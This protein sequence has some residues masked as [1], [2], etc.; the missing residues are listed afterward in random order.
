MTTVTLND[1]SEFHAGSNL[2]QDM[3]IY[4]FN[5]FTKLSFYFRIKKGYRLHHRVKVKATELV[6]KSTNSKKKN[7]LFGLK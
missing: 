2:F 5:S 1:P 3:Q 7:K 6:Y 4:K